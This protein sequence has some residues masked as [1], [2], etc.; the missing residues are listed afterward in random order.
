MKGNTRLCSAAVLLKR[1]KYQWMKEIPL[2]FTGI[3]RF[4]ACNITHC[5]YKMVLPNAPGPIEKPYFHNQ[6]LLVHLGLIQC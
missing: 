4:N 1:L 5:L 3:F 2:L 6:S